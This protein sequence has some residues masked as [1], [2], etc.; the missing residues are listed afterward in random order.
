ML[1]EIQGIHI[2][3]KRWIESPDAP[4]SKVSPFSVDR[5]KRR[6]FT[7]EEIDGMAAFLRRHAPATMASLTDRKVGFSGARK[8]PFS[9]R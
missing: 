8:T 1:N 2:L 3:L 4:A 7:P 6:P 9:V 5:N